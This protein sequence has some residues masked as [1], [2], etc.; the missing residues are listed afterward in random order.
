[1]PQ[2]VDDHL[3]HVGLVVAVR[4]LEEKEARRLRDDD[5]AVREHEAGRDVQ[6][7]GEDGE[8]VRLAVA[9]GVLANLDAVVALAVRLSRRADNRASP[10]PSSRPRSSHA[11]AIG[12]TMSGSP[13]KSSSR[14]SAGTCVR[15]MLPFTLSGCWK[16]SG[17]GPLLVVRHVRV[18]LRAS[19]ARAGRETFPTRAP[20]VARGGEQLASRSRGEI[21]RRPG[22][23][24]ARTPATTFARASVAQSS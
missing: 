13:A 19:P 18:G 1:M 23:R 10:R 16:V 21:R 24:R 2:P 22:Y 7:V 5:A 9:V 6:L 20:R 15:S 12:F 4:V 3:A 11:K 14:I 8:L 17:C